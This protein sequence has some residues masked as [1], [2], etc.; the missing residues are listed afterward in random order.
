MYQVLIA[1]T[2][3]YNIK[4]LEALSVWGKDSDFE[5]AQKVYQGEQALQLLRQ[6][7]YDL[8]LAEI[9]LPGL[10]GLQLLRHINQEGLCPITVI[11]SD[12]VEF[13]YVRECILYGVF[14]YLKKM[15]DGETMQKLLFRAREQLISQ[16]G[17]YENERELR[18]PV[19]AE[20]QIV[21]ALSNGNE[22]GIRLFMETVTDLYGMENETPFHN[23]V[24]VKKLYLNVITRIFDRYRWLYHYTTI[25][26]YKRLDYLL[27][28]SATG[29]ADFYKRKLTHLFEL[30]KRL[31]LTSADSN[32]TPLLEYI[33]DNP[34][35]DLK[36][37][38]VA[39]KVYLNYSY[40][41][42]TFSSQLEIH[43]NEYI[44]NVKMARAAFLLQNTGMKVYEICGALSYQDANYFTRQFKKIYGMS[45]SEFKAVSNGD[46]FLDYSCL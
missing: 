43:Y 42:S 36:L 17:T 41:S 20:E 3:E 13:Q 34:E 39:Q 2:I 4:Q 22:D 30:V 23:D 11:L 44:T 32:L 25:D 40:L 26:F 24:I 10:D 18:Y 21:R 7:H 15:P 12:T 28:G 33:L 9:D 35:E 27:V 31:Y 19:N 46:D 8:V 38:T 45:P 16:G 5:I 37:K 6:K 29:F 1:G 14:D